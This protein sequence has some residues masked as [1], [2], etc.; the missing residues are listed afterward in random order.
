M[1][2]S[3]TRITSYNVCYTKLLRLNYYDLKQERSRAQK[4][5]LDVPLDLML[6]DIGEGLAPGAG[7]R[8]V[9]P[10]QVTSVPLKAFLNGLT[11][12]GMWNSEPMSVDFKSFMS[13]L[14]RTP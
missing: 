7:T 13:S 6:I 11:R 14:T 10:S 3:C 1:L 4:L 5:K 2:P 9:L 8:A 12:E